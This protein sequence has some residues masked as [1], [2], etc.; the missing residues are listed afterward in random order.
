M[1]VAQARTMQIP[2]SVRM[3]RFWRAHGRSF[4]HLVLL[5][6]L[7]ITPARTWTP[8]R[9]RSWYGI[10]ADRARAIL[11]ELQEC[12]IVRRA[13]GT[14]ESYRWNGDLDWAVPRDGY[15]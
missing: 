12:G 7:S 3:R 14:D 2:P 13:E 5:R 8:D 1:S 11:H 4:E 6:V 9:L 10:H 15:Q